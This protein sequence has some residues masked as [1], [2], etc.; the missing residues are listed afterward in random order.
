[1]AAGTSCRLRGRGDRAGDA[2]PSADPRV[3]VQRVWI[4]SEGRCRST[5]Q[6]I[7]HAFLQNSCPSDR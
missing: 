1:M 3:S 4:A 2:R 6:L 7:M 5:Q